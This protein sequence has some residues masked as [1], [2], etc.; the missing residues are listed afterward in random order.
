MLCLD[1][2]Y[3]NRIS[4][5]FTY[6][7]EFPS[8]PAVLLSSMGMSLISDVLC[9]PQYSTIKSSFMVNKIPK[10][11]LSRWTKPLLGTAHAFSPCH[12]GDWI[13]ANLLHRLV[14]IY[15]P[16]DPSNLFVHRDKEIPETGIFA[17]VAVRSIFTRKTLAANP[18][19]VSFSF[20]LLNGIWVSLPL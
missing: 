20:Y 18:L 4:F 3:N 14:S 13:D 7:L 9:T 2:N 10:I 17:T 1:E 8:I 16:Q 15:G 6:S 11:Y 19:R 12:S 5:T